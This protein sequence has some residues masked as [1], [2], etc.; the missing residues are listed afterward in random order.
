MVLTTKYKSGKVYAIKSPNTDKMYIGSTYQALCKR[1]AVHRDN[2]KNGKNVSSKIILE[3][4]DAYAELIELYPCETREQ[5]VKKEGEHIKANRD[6]AVNKRIAGRTSQEWY[7]HN[8]INNR[9]A[10]LQY[11]RDY[12]NANKDI[13]KI[14]RKNYYLQNRERVIARQLAYVAKKKLQ[15]KIIV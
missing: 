13:V 9:D 11:Q 8:S 12:Y 3:A 6:K 15:A 1:M 2:W 14:K 10:F 4:G 7:Q 5:L